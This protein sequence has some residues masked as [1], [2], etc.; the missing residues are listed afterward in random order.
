MAKLI[1]NEENKKSRIEPEIYGHFS[2]HLGRCIYEGI[3][4][5]EKSEIPNVNGMRTDVVDALKELKVPESDFKLQAVSCSG[6]TDCK[7][8]LLKAS[9]G[10]LK[11]NFIE[12]MACES[13]CIGG[14]AC[15]SH[16]AKNR[17]QFSKYERLDVE[18]TISDSIENLELDEH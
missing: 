8:A 14:P 13:G 4:V 9:K 1:I 3:Y 18:K 7:A 15:L 11:E 5:G 2:E 16:G 12:G 6:L 17:L 10:I